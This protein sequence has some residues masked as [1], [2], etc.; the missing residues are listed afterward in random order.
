MTYK[1]TAQVEVYV[2]A[3]SEAEAYDKAHR[4]ITFGTDVWFDSDG[5]IS[6]EEVEE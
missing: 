5:L 2:E 1:V 6:I 4:E 3:S